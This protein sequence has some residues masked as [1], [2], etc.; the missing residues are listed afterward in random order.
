MDEGAITTS[1]DESDD[2]GLRLFREIVKEGA[3]PE[4]R[5]YVHSAVSKEAEVMKVLTELYGGGNESDEG[6]G[7]LVNNAAD[8][9]FDKVEE[10]SK[11]VFAVNVKCQ[12]FTFKHSQI[13]ALPTLPPYRCL[14]LIP[15]LHRT[16]PARVPSCK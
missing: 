3:A 7:T 12:L 6:P 8:F 5:R 11:K 4:C 1:C 14:W 13:P 10:S 9:L 2:K 16:T 15:A